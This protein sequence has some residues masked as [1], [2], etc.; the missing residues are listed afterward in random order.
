MNIEALRQLCLEKPHATEEVKWEKDLCFMIGAKMFCITGLDHATGASLKVSDE[1]FAELV[2]QPGIIPAPYL[3]RYKWVRIDFDATLKV[4][5]WEGL[6][7]QS[8][9]LI[10]AKLSNKQ[11]DKLS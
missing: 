7:D 6:I 9:G 10:K 2:E 4:R 3:A 11:Q 1:K 5:D 8:Y